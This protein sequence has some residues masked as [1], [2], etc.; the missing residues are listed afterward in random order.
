MQKQR[1]WEL[2][3]FRGLFV[4]A[5]VAVHLVYN[6]QSF[7]NLPFLAESRVYHFIAD[8]GGVLFFL[9]CGIC[10]TL[11]SRPVRRGLIVFGCGVLIWAVTMA[12]Y[13]LD[14]ADKSF[15]IWFGVLHCLG[16]CMLLWPAL[17]KLPWWALLIGAVVL[18]PAGLI[19]N[20][21][22]FG[23][24]MWLVFLGFMP[25]G[26]GSSDYF[27]LLPFF[28]FFLIG[29]V[30]GKTLYKHKKTRFP[31]ISAENPVIRVF[32]RIGRL[33]LWIYILHQPLLLGAMY[34]LEAVL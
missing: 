1:I 9:L 14:M 13:L 25:A 5:M 31:R 3:A 15:V 17:R 23:T 33:S 7:F 19:L 12:M 2:D 32:C 27:P 29:A 22:R 8:G 10:V 18:I 24:G 16:S 6:L 34:A 30:L 4:L 21:M 20:R 28:G 26:F 11:G